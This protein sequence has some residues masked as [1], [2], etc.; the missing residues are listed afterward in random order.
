MTVPRKHWQ[1]HI[2]DVVRSR[3]YTWLPEG[4]GGQPV[5]VAMSCLVTDIMH[6]CRRTGTPW[7]KVVADATARFEMEQRELSIPNTVD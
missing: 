5:D 7:S 3:H 2:E 6:V 4:L 1:D